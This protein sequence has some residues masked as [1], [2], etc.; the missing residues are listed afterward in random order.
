MPVTNA[1]KRMQ[2]PRKPPQRMYDIKLKEAKA[3]D[4]DTVTADPISKSSRE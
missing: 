4:C 3:R 2:G 1:K